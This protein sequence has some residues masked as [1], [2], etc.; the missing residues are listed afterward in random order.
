MNI[1]MTGKN[2]KDDCISNVVRLGDFVFVSGQYGQ[3]NTFEKEV[4]DLFEKIEE[5]LAEFELDYRHIVKMNIYLTNLDDK[6]QVLEI[7]QSYFERP[8]P[9]CSIVEVQRL[10][11]DAKLMI[12]AFAINTLP[13][14]KKMKDSTCSGCSCC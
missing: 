1:F 2:I 11:M 4:K 9:A 14:E 3:G 10:E 7:Y 8:F 6:N 5:Q 12:D 13:Y